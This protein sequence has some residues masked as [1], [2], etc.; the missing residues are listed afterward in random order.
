MK[1]YTYNTFQK[2]INLDQ[3]PLTVPN[4]TLTDALNATILTMNGNEGILQ[5]D[6][7]NGR[8][9][10]AFLP[11]G[12]VPVGIKE[13]GGII[14]VASYNPLTNKGQIGSFPSPE[15]NYNQEELTNRQIELELL[16]KPY[17]KSF[18][19]FDDIT[20]LW[21][22]ENKVQIL[23]QPI[24]SGDK[25]AICF[26]SNDRNN[27][28]NLKYISFTERNLVN[29]YI[30][31]LDAN[32]NLR[33]ITD[34]LKIVDNPSI[35][36]DKY[37]MANVF[38]PTE[39]ASV[40]EIRNIYAN[41]LNTYNN[42][43]FGKLFLVGKVNVVDHIDAYVDVNVTGNKYKFTWTVTYYY[44][45]PFKYLIGPQ[46]N[47]KIGKDTDEIKK[48]TTNTAVHISHGA[49]TQY[50]DE[51]YSCT[52]TITTSKN[53][54]DVADKIM[55]Y[56][57]VPKMQNIPNSNQ[58]INYLPHIAIEGTVNLA[59][60]GTGKIDINRWNY[61]YQGSLLTL[62]YGFD[63]DI[64]GKYKFSDLIFECENA[65]DSSD[66]VTIKIPSKAKYSGVFT[67]MFS[68]LD[69]GKIYVVTPK[70][71][72]NEDTPLTLSKRIIITT[73][74]YNDLFQEILDYGDASNT[75]TL[76]AIQEHN[77]L[78]FTNKT[79]IKLAINNPTIVD[80]AYKIVKEGNNISEESLDGMLPYFSTEKDI[81]DYTL[82]RKNNFNVSETIELDLT[83]DLD[84]YPF[85]KI[86]WSNNP[87]ISINSSIGEFVQDG[88]FTTKSDNTYTY[89]GTVSLEK[90]AK[91]NQTTDPTQYT[92]T[93][94]K[95]IANSL[96]NQ[97]QDQ[98]FICPV[99]SSYDGAERGVMDLIKVNSFN[100]ISTWDDNQHV[101]YEEG[102]KYIK[103]EL[104]NDLPFWEKI[105]WILNDSSKPFILTS[106]DNVHSGFNTKSSNDER[107]NFLKTC[108]NSD[109][110]PTRVNTALFKESVISGIYINIIDILSNEAIIQYGPNTDAGPK[111]YWYYLF[112]KDSSGRF[113]ILNVVNKNQ[114]CY[115]DLST[116]INDL[117][118]DLVNIYYRSENSS[119]MLLYK[120]EP[121]QKEESS[122]E[123][124]YLINS[125][126]NIDIISINDNNIVN[127][128]L[129]INCGNE[130]NKQLLTFT[131]DYSNI[132]INSQKQ[133]IPVVGF[134][135]FSISNPDG[136]IENTE[137]LTDN[138]GQLLK[139]NFYYYNNG[140]INSKDYSNFTNKLTIENNNIIVK[141][142]LA[143]SELD[144]SFAAG[145]GITRNIPND[146]QWV[147][148]KN[149]Q[150]KVLYIPDLGDVY[151][152]TRVKLKE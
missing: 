133:Q 94:Y 36:G 34:Q 110:T 138:E 54:E 134:D 21:Q 63:I 59:L 104:T 147:H 88:N 87:N 77:K 17:V 95:S 144:Y 85:N 62:N 8:V 46:V 22:L 81:N 71:K 48:L 37:F 12:Y 26:N 31:V 70:I 91:F 152:E 90:F 105:D 145:N 6:M 5:N 116:M 136:V 40:D 131:I 43:L 93:L 57:I 15:R 124:L 68:Q 113:V 123:E 148:I 126:N 13:H 97:L 25:F 19:N 141:Y 39:G 16:N 30:Q 80:Q 125:I 9:E 139:N 23:D 67:E 14:Y 127:N 64:S 4:D 35:E 89:S 44:K 51:L 135:N 128:E 60:I 106:L 29:L 50:N 84:K 118:G 27:G 61:K 33:D 130:I 52:Y 140:I 72:R 108:I 55:Y 117:L 20:G 100:L 119:S 73:T 76:R 79:N 49:E 10:S 1:K 3:H 137:C 96:I 32:N 66:K 11:S 53:K 38:P 107:K 47:F 115:D 75:E 2:G 18:N 45:C 74:I 24:R 129:V 58:T 122:N 99:I 120:Q 41:Y 7:G 143:D 78:I 56:R 28:D 42:K 150:F 149:K 92:V 102:T 112:M 121:Y 103:K 82:H 132:T 98:P 109:R 151:N 101:L 86:V 83:L 65:L 69:Q 142:S 146:N 111:H 114:K